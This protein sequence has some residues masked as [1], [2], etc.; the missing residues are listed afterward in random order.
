MFVSLLE[1]A[2]ATC[3]QF[4]DSCREFSKID[5]GFIGDAMAM[6]IRC[7][8]FL[9]F[10]FHMKF[11]VKRLQ[12]LIIHMIKQ[13]AAFCN[14]DIITTLSK[15]SNYLQFQVRKILLCLDNTLTIYFSLDNFSIYR[16]VPSQHFDI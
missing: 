6:T 15:S 13:V 11:Q 14:L 8:Q 2:H 5:E 3:R 16:R 7:S 10:F 12:S 1:E 9:D 4:E